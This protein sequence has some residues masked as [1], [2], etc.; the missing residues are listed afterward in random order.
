MQKWLR[1]GMSLLV[2][3]MVLPLAAIAEATPPARNADNMPY[4]FDVFNGTAVDLTQY[5]GKAVWLNFFTGW[6]KYCMEEM[7][8]I[9]KAFE[10][11]STDE[12][13]IVLVHVWDGEDADD[14]AAVVKQFGLEGMTVVEDKDM[15]LAALVS[16]SG[17]PTSIFIGKDGYL[18]S[19]AYAL[20]YDTMAETID[21]MGVA[22]AAATP[23]ATPTAAVP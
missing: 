1:R 22:K 12:L 14:S 23:D 21:E 2:A 16:L 9:K 8:D 10:T 11:Y 17:Y 18:A 13:A 19:V 15:S 4:V 7:P 3:L 5:K 6:C 20:K